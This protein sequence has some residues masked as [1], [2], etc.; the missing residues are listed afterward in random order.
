MKKCLKEH[1]ILIENTLIKEKGNFNWNALSDFNQKQI[2]IFQHERLVHLLITLFFGL[3]FFGSIV[4]ELFLLNVGLLII[5][6]ILLIMLPFYVWHYFVLENGVQKLYQ[7]DKKIDK[8]LN[9]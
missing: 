4:V 1:I 7:L 3:I 8:H 5:S 9:K 2:R 6:I